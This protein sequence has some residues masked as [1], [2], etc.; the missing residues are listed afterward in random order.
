MHR[1]QGPEF[2]GVFYVTE[3]PPEAESG[4]DLE[5]LR[6]WQRQLMVAITRGRD[7]AWVG[8]VRR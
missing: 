4:A 6:Q 1:A 3:P 2:F 7:H 8:L 5:R